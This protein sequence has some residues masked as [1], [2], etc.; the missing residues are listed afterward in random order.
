LMLPLAAAC[1]PNT[2]T[3]GDA[4]VTVYVE[5]TTDSAGFYVA[6]H[7]GLFTKA[8][9]KIKLVQSPGGSQVINSQYLKD[10]DISGVNYV[11]YIEAQEL[12][13]LGDQT[14]YIIIDP[15]PGEIA[16]NLDVFA[17]ASVMNPG[18]VGLFT[19]SGSPIK[20]VT[21]LKGKVIGINQPNNIDYLMLAAFLE[22]YGMSTSDVQLAYYGYPQLAGALQDHKIQAAFLVEPYI[23]IAEEHSGVTEL[24]NLDQGLTESFPIEGYATTK[25]WARA[26]PQA[27]AAFQQALQ[28][29]QEIA[30]TNREE[31][32]QALEAELP[33]VTP[34]VAAL[35]TL[36]DYP[37]GAVDSTRLQRVADDMVQFGLDL[38][39]FNVSNMIG[40]GTT[41]AMASG[42]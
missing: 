19:L 13:D 38:Q 4:T 37:S 42:S 20:T 7:E 30:D 5:P 18:S 25:A 12:S 23:T 22:D 3:G 9:L 6:L 21:Q 41:S 33:N 27:F 26:N 32:E 35:L 31:T 8:G 40:T 29:G 16:A 11:S 36:D 17:E 28:Q 39:T 14:S 34:H 2:D 15:A 1:T 10:C 24:S